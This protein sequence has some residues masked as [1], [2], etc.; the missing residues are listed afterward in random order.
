MSAQAQA[1]EGTRRGRATAM[2]L[3][4]AVHALRLSGT[5]ECPFDFATGGDSAD[6]EL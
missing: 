6:S 2:R 5:E 1:Q 4:A 3:V